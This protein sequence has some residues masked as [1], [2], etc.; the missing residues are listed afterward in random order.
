MAWRRLFES[1]TWVS[2]AHVPA[3]ALNSER[4]ILQTL[5]TKMRRSSNS[6]STSTEEEHYEEHE[7]RVQH[8][9][10]PE[11]QPQDGSGNISAS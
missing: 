8:A 11:Q 3:Q 2:V 6:C 5:N 7:E 1:C 4:Y 10:E 9:A